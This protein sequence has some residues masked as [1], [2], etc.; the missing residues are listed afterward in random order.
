MVW[1]PAGAEPAACGVGGGGALTPSPWPLPVFL[2]TPQAG[3]QPGSPCPCQL[4]PKGTRDMG[5]CPVALT[6]FESALSPS[7][8]LLRRSQ[9]TFVA[10][11][12]LGVHDVACMLH[13]VCWGFDVQTVAVGPSACNVPPVDGD[14]RA[15]L[16][17]DARAHWR[18][19]LASCAFPRLL[20]PCLGFRDDAAPRSTRH[21]MWAVD[22]GDSTASGLGLCPGRWRT[23]AECIR[24]AGVPGL[25]VR[26]ASALVRGRASALQASGREK[27]RAESGFPPCAGVPPGPEGTAM[28][29][30]PLSVRVLLGLANQDAVRVLLPGRA[31]PLQCSVQ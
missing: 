29:Y 8:D 25:F 6:T 4:L 17:W 15:L 13:G 26:A 22:V 11:M 21:L 30:V 20:V 3:L 5:V 18:D 31:G 27:G 14:A 28:L 16:M 24:T 1:L 10:D 19:R 23:R 2:D 9:Y 7:D 12:F